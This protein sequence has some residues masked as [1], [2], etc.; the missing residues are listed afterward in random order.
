MP[1][2]TFYAVEPSPAP[3]AMPIINFKG[4]VTVPLRATRVEEDAYFLDV[5]PVPLRAT[6][7]PSVKAE[8]YQ[9]FYPGEVD[10]V[11][12]CLAKVLKPRTQNEQQRLAKAVSAIEILNLLCSLGNG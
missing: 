9:I 12:L 8:L 2:G 6:R 3:Q 7:Q 1:P 5:I 4:G 11:D 10:Y